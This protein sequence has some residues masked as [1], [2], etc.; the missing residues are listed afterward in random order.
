MSRAHAASPALDAV[1]LTFLGR[2]AELSAVGDPSAL[3]NARA[4]QTP[5]LFWPAWTARLMPPLRGTSPQERRRCLSAVF[6]TVTARTS[7]TSATRMLGGAITYSSGAPILLRAERDPR[8]PASL[9][10]LT[11]LAAHLDQHGTPVDYQ[12]RRL[13]G[14]DTLL[15]DTRWIQICRGTGAIPGQQSRA[16]TARRWLF[17][18][19]SGT[20]ADL[21]PAAFAVTTPDQRARLDK[22]SALITPGLAVGLDSYAGAWL[23]GNHIDGEEVTWRPPARPAAQR[24]G[25]ARTRPFRLPAR[26]DPQADYA[27][28]DV[29]PRGCPPRGHHDRRRPRR[30]RRASRATPAADPRPG[31]LCRT[32]GRSAPRPAVPARAGRPLRRPEHQP[33]ATQPPIRSKQEHRSRSA[34]RI[35][36]SPARRP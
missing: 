22:F 21:A 24:P 31:T 16:L 23:A 17:E 33:A 2:V 11:R 34:R 6:L 32:R 28:P 15:P 20:P 9:A 4:R 5:A 1:R 29:T 26:P 13:L 30:P 35:R 7:L 3:A 18:R 12:R 36:D 10:A 25:P 19:I 27:P 8:W 14:Y